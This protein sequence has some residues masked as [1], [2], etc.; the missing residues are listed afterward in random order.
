[1]FFSVSRI[2]CLFSWS[3]LSLSLY[4]YICL[5]ALTDWLID[6]HWFR[7]M[8]WPQ[9]HASAEAL[10]H[11]TCWAFVW[12]YPLHDI[13]SPILIKSW[14]NTSQRCCSGTNWS[15]ALRRAT[16]LPAFA[17]GNSSFDRVWRPCLMVHQSLSATTRLAQERQGNGCAG[18]QWLEDTWQTLLLLSTCQ[19]LRLCEFLRQW[20]NLLFDAKILSRSDLQSRLPFDAVRETAPLNPHRWLPCS[21]VSFSVI[22]KTTTGL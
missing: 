16:N 8:I 9:Q 10:A 17:R 4:I 5:Y 19:H 11:V 1:M 15:I 14:W 13:T 6:Y 3:H 7:L 18:R 12:C 2:V 20:D 22:P 21:L